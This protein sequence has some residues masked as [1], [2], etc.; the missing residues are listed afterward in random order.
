NGADPGSK[1]IAGIVGVH[2]ATALHTVPRTPSSTGIVVAMKEAVASRVGIDEAPDGPVFG[3][4]FWL[5]AAPSGA[6]A[7]D[8]DGSFDRNAH[9]IEFLV[10]FA[11]AIVH[12]DQR[13]R[14]VAVGGISV[15][16]WKLFG[17]LIR[18]WID[19]ESGF[20][21]LCAEFCGSDEFNDAV[22]GSGEEDVEIFDMRLKSPFFEAGQDPLRVV[23]VI[24]RANVVRACGEAA[25]VFADIAGHRGVLKFLFE[26][27][28]CP[29]GGG[30]VA[31]GRLG[32]G[33]RSGLWSR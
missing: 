7:R 8:D 31:G 2:N 26:L 14:Y 33:G 21:Q 25:H 30:R 22:L 1:R 29:G 12:V 24:H 15:I 28:L 32:G 20:L 27:A 5:D 9:A 17:G 18:G 16:G 6:I 23:F 11:I 13:S 19:G 10:V 3:G 4:D